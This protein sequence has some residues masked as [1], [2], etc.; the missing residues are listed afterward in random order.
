M[1]K[2][3][4]QHKAVIIKIAQKRGLH[5]CHRRFLKR[6]NR[7]GINIRSNLQ[8]CSFCQF[9]FSK[10]SQNHNLNSKNRAY[11]KAPSIFSF[12]DNCEG[13]CAFF[14]NFLCSSFNNKAKQVVFDQLNCQN[15][16]LCAETV[17]SV[18]FKEMH[19]YGN[20]NLSGIYPQDD[21][22]KHIVR[23]SGVTKYL[24]IS[25][26][27]PPDMFL[28]EL[29]EGK[30]SKSKFNESS[31]KE[32]QSTA[33]IEYLNKCLNK[34]GWELN[35]NGKTHFATIVGELLDNAEIHSKK[36]HWWINA[37]L[38]TI[39]PKKGECH[40]V[41]FNFGQSISESMQTL[42]E[43]SP[44]RK[45]IEQLIAHHQ[46][47]HL[48][49][50]QWDSDVLWTLYSLQEGVSSLAGLNSQSDHG[51]GLSDL[52]EFFQELGDNEDSPHIM[53]LISGN[54]YIRFDN[55][56]KIKSQYHNSSQRR[57]IAFN[58]NNDLYAP[59]DSRKVKKMRHFFPGTIC[60]FKFNIDNDYLENLKNESNNNRP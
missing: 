53:A 38:Q 19:R 27:N 42:P 22:L 33:L 36:P 1:K 49:S 50:S 28:F 15:I 23:A 11:C 2:F 35:N 9:Y 6:K 47:R 32:I 31:K 4:F 14:E 8:Q 48:F 12:I 55:E 3:D 29:R 34:C 7:R 25:K 60:T 37:Y 44:H 5:N 54:V 59:P 40:L 51:Q 46:K 56:Y 18:L 57:Q 58:K 52:I 17:A 41:I 45:K 21:N 26:D 16:D 30:K 10:I 13:T 39:G 20:K 43:E 24:K